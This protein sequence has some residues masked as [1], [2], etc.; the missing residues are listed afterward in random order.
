MEA[1]LRE[2]EVSGRDF[3]WALFGAALAPRLD[4]LD[5]N[6]QRDDEHPRR[7]F[8]RQ[9]GHLRFRRHR[10]GICHRF[11][12]YHTISEHI[13]WFYLGSLAVLIYT[14]LAARRIAG[15]KSWIDLGPV[16]V[17]P[18]E[19]IKMVVVVAMARYL[20]DLHVKGYLSFNQIVKAGVICG[21]PMGLILLQPDM[22]T[23]LTYMPILGVGCAAAGREAQGDRLLSF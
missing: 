3:D 8:L 16:S 9:A 1:T 4:R 18:S 13:P 6:L 19:I 21:I 5:G 15:A 2:S 20:S 14:P 10:S 17:Q 23:A 7:C 12:D 11:V 22:G